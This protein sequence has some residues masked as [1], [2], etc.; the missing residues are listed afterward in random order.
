MIFCRPGWPWTHHVSKM[1][2][3]P[4]AFPVLNWQRVLPCLTSSNLKLK[5]RA[6]CCGGGGCGC[7]KRLHTTVEPLECRL[8]MSAMRNS[9]TPISKSQLPKTQP[10]NTYLTNNFILGTR[11][12]SFDFTKCIVPAILI[13][14]T[15][16]D[17]REPLQS[18]VTGQEMFGQVWW[19][20]TQAFI[21]K[22]K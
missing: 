21:L 5:A 1:T 7:Y 22:Q 10:K 20:A 6:A 14:S 19:L 18:Y 13:C 17:L 16:D 4:W 15:F 8:N 12:N 2:V 3:I 9:Y 11:W